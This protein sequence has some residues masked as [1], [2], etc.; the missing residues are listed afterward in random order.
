MDPRGLEDSG[1]QS[2]RGLINAPGCA[3]L[4]SLDVQVGGGGVAPLSVTIPSS[5]QLIGL[6]SY[7]QA[8]LLGDPN[9]VPV[10]TTSAA[11]IS[12]F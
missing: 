9:G 6:N 7:W 2:G 4:T 8:L 5:P 10:V 1:K 11:A 3:V 12:L